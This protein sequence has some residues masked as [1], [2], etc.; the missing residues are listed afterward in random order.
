MFCRVGVRS[1]PFKLDKKESHPG[2]KLLVIWAKI[3]LSYLTLSFDT[4][5]GRLHQGV[6]KLRLIAKMNT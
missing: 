5:G 6:F 4:I 2:K 1:S 3:G